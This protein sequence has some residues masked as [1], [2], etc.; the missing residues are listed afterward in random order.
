MKCYINK[1]LLR[2]QQAGWKELSETKYTEQRMEPVDTETRR[3]LK[4]N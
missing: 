2:R 1:L 4:K 3:I